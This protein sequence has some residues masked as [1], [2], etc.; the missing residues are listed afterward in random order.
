MQHSAQNI[1]TEASTFTHQIFKDDTTYA[2]VR[3]HLSDIEDVITEE[4]IS[5]MVT[6][7][8]PATEDEFKKVAHKEGFS[9][10]EIEAIRN[11]R[12]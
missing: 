3:K 11:A 7:M 5:R 6:E 12:N 8:S 9:D 10:N 1:L 2:K 4:D